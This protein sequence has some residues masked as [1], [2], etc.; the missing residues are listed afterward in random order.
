MSITL[1]PYKAIATIL[2]ALVASLVTFNV[3]V[4]FALTM[5]EFVFVLV[6]TIGA[7][8][9]VSI[10]WPQRKQLATTMP[11]RLQA[12]DTS[13]LEAHVPE[14]HAPV[15]APAESAVPTPVSVPISQVKKPSEPSSLFPADAPEKLSPE[16]ARQWLDDF[17]RKQQQ[18]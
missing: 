15:V 3:G 14:V 11:M 4:L 6:A 17:L 5:R 10:N 9:L 16:A 1:T 18:K 8:F 7:V 2:W 13:L 12:G